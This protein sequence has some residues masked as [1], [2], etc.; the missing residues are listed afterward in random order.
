MMVI[1]NGEEAEVGSLKRG[2]EVH[3]RPFLPT[4]PQGEEKIVVDTHLRKEL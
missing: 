2:R 4:Y 3:F 1:A